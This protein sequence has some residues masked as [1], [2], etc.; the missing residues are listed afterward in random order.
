[1]TGSID[2]FDCHQHFGD[3]S[4]FLGLDGPAGDVTNDDPAQRDVQDRLAFMDATGIHQAAIIPSHSYDRSR[5]LA[6]NCRVNDRIASLRDA[7]P[8]RLPAAVGVVEPMFAAN[9]AA[10]VRRCARELGLAGISFHPRFQGTSMDSPSIRT[11]TGHMVDEGLVPL[12]HAMNE[13]VDESL[14]KV[15]QLAREFPG[16]PMLVLDAFCTFEGSKEVMFVADICPSLLFDTS[17]SAN[18]DFGPR[19]VQRF[20]AER[21]V[22]GTD[23]YRPGAADGPSPMLRAILSSSLSDADKS[24]ILSGNARR[25]FR[26]GRPLGGFRPVQRKAGRTWSRNVRSHS[27]ASPAS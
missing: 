23:L 9:G 2:V 19:F 18:F 21:L 11:L 14:W 15:A 4:E 3:N 13:S 7:V 8:D 10:E 16:T 1:M 25:L 22:F 27:S 17:L 6:D 12:L 26:L 5:G 24:S 20:G